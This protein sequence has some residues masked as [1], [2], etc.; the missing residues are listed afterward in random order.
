MKLHRAAA[1]AA[2]FALF[3]ALLNRA[4]L[5]PE[6]P[7]TEPTPSSKLEL[8]RALAPCTEPQRCASVERRSLRLKKALTHVQ[9]GSARKLRWRDAPLP[10][11]R[12]TFLNTT[13]V[14]ASCRS[15]D[16]PF[17]QQLEDSVREILRRTQTNE[18]VFT[19]VDQ[20][21][22]DLLE[23]NYNMAQK[24]GFSDGL[25]Y[26]SLDRHTAE[27]ACSKR[28]RVAFLAKPPQATTKDVVYLG[29]YYAAMLLCKAR[30]RFFFWEMDLWLP[31]RPSGPSVVDV[32]R[33]AASAPTA[34]L[35]PASAWA[36]HEDNPY[37]INIG[38][39]YIASD[40]DERSYDLFD[41]LL[42]YLRRHPHAFD[43]GLVNCVLKKVISH[44]RI[45]YI[46]DRD[47]CKVDGFDTDERGHL[48]DG[49]LQS[50]I[51]KTRPGKMMGTG[52][53]NFTLV[54]GVVAASYALPFLFR[55]T[56]AVHVLSSVPLSSSFGKKVVAKELMLW[57]DDEDYFHVRSGRFLALDGV[58]AVPS[59]ADDFVYL[60]DRLT[61]LCALARQTNRIL[62]LPATWHLS[63]RLQAWELVELASLES[64]GVGWRE[65]T[66]LANPRLKVDEDALF[67]SL[68]LTPMGASVRDTNGDGV[69]YDASFQK[70][71][72]RSAHLRF[73]VHVSMHDKRCRDAA[74]LFVDVDSKRGLA[75]A[76]ART[77]FETRAIAD[78][79][80]E[81]WLSNIYNHLTFCDYKHREKRR[82]ALVGAA[83]E[84][85][86]QNA[87]KRKLQE[88]MH[89]K[90]LQRA[91]KLPK[92][93]ETVREGRG[94]LSVEGRRRAA[95][96][97]ALSLK[98]DVARTKPPPIK[99]VAFGPYPDA[100][101]SAFG[102]WEPGHVK[103]ANSPGG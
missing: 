73:L 18:V 78:E 103:T 41:T 17:E 28:K 76:P 10:A 23:A 35:R 44:R 24:A 37:T 97:F 80:R 48:V 63:R 8:A 62:I 20:A 102:F 92:G 94:S 65:A 86:G 2:T 88:D 39:Y 38:L 31:P 79:K 30:I 66:Y 13:R 43:Q 25:F 32:F 36:L 59:G 45:N 58:L 57:E 77:P 60:K 12:P 27:D 50:L 7:V 67:V 51:L 84:C 42:D 40:T 14:A 16:A 55:D 56:L 53:Y 81:P 46:K 22:G 101:A 93:V 91:G 72:T 9:T 82:V 74:V 98:D 68:K 29:K 21:Y 52:N 89:K 85:G 15:L 47:N 4:G 19:I 34:G 49:A 99:E 70:E 64:L 33:A 75:V 6:L 5:A 100:F 3:T 95:A 1:A 90:M 61:E 87:G 96:S 26:V 11:T 69:Q 71:D 54:D 83:F